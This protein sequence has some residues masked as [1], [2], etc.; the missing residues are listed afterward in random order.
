M[1]S[2]DS[3]RNLDGE[4]YEYYPLDTAT[5]YA[6]LPDEHELVVNKRSGKVTLVNWERRRFLAESSFT[7]Q[8]LPLVRTLLSDWPS[9]VPYEKILVLVSDELQQAILQRLEE[10]RQMKTLETVLEPVR[11][12]L[13]EC[14]ERV[15]L[16]GINIAAVYEH[17]YLLI[18]LSHKG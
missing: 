6:L 4:Q 5:G 13:K 17:G 9:Y 1:D 3:I 8:E 11:S 14:Q 7:D 18:P 12:I 2:T 10:A 16:F 15:N